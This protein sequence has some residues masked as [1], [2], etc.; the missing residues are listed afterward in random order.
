VKT[1]VEQLQRNLARDP[2]DAP[3]VHVQDACDLQD[4][5][6]MPEALPADVAE[7]GDAHACTGR[8]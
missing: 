2:G 6:W 8:Q 7:D 1:L 4:L 3:A 5:W